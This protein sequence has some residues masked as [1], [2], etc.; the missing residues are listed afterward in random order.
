MHPSTN[1]HQAILLFL[2]KASA[3]IIA[4]KL[5]AVGYPVEAVHTVTELQL[6]L[7]AA[8][9]CLVITT[10]PCIDT[11]RNIQPLPVVNLEV[12]FH[13]IPSFEVPVSETKQFDTKAF[14]A[15]IKALSEPKPRR[16][17][18]DLARIAPSSPER[19]TRVR[20]WQR[21]LARIREATR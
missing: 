15:R 12:F 3:Q 4:S 11:V 6:A 14:L 21:L 8:D 17:N 20:L 7:K 10:R 2:P 1:N 19:E 13:F 16:N 18:A 9:Y 5:N